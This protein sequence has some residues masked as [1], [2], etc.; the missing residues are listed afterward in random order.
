MVAAGAAATP[1]HLAPWP[2]LRPPATPQA[3]LGSAVA[4]VRD[5]GLWAIL[6]ISRFI[7]PDP[8][9]IKRLLKSEIHLDPI[10]LG[11]LPNRL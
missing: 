4:Y 1:R 5:L 10:P 11:L 6:P 2:G 8:W 3:A 7:D 9:A